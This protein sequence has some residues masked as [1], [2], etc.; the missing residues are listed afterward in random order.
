[1][2]WS[3]DD[4]GTAAEA[5]R[6]LRERFGP[7]L[8]ELREGWGTDI[9]SLLIRLRSSAERRDPQGVAESAHGIA[10]MAAIL[11]ARRIEALA[12]DLETRAGEGETGGEE[13]RIDALTDLVEAFGELLRRAAED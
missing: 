7:L 3:P 10:G 11:G 12:R 4:G 9:P 1:M 8:T 6:N 13:G 5:I 2:T